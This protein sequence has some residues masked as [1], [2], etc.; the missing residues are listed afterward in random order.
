MIYWCN[1]V[2]SGCRVIREMEEKHEAAWLWRERT[3]TLLTSLKT[4]HALWFVS[5]ILRGGVLNNACVNLCLG[6]QWLHPWP[7]DLIC[8]LWPVVICWGQMSSYSK[9]WELELVKGRTCERMLTQLKGW[10]GCAEDDGLDREANADVHIRNR[11]I[12]DMQREL[13]RLMQI[14]R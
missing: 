6:G 4:H 7:V 1:Y 12:E 11:H 8:V 13:S 10:P 5:C 3:H 2:S 14:T 9:W